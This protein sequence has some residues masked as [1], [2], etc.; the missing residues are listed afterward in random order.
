MATKT[1]TTDQIFVRT[2]LLLVHIILNIV[3]ITRLTDFDL[4]GSWLVFTGFILLVFILLFLFIRHFL[5]F[6]QFLKNK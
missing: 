2:A 4:T 6:F 3:V 5:S 1:K